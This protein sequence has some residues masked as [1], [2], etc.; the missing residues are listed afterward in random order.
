VPVIVSGGLMS[1]EKAKYV[2][3]ITGAEGIML[4]RGALGNPW[5]FQRVLGQ[6]DGMPTIAEVIEEWSWIVDRAGEHYEDGRAARYLRKFHPWYLER[7]KEIDPENFTR[8]RINE[9][10]QQLQQVATLD[11]TRSVLGRVET[12]LAA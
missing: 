9:I 4:A 5:L 6:R 11:E 2:M 7:L 10:N 1:E 12:P 8:A 3:E